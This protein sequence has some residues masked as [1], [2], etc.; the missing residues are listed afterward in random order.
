MGSRRHNAD[1]ATGLL[2]GLLVAAG[3]VAGVMWLL[4]RRRRARTRPDRLPRL[5]AAIVGNT[6][7]NV[8]AVL[9]PPRV[10]TF[11]G[12]TSGNYQD[13]AVW[14]YPLARESRLGMAIKFGDDRAQKVDI[15]RGPEW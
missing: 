15:I 2:G 11:V 8:A 1:L 4:R 12:Q 9:G 3:V 7:A 14:Y 10:A 13:A 6:K 5:T